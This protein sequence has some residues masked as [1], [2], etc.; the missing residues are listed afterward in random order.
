MSTRRPPLPAVAA[1]LVAVVAATTAGILAYSSDSP[2]RTPARTASPSPAPSTS[3]EAVAWKQ[4]VLTDLNP[5]KGVIVA[6]I[7]TL[8]QWQ[9]GKATTASVVGSVDHALPQFLATAAL[10]GKRAPFPGAPR[11][12]EDYQRAVALYVQSARVAR[13]AT[14]VATGPLQEQLGLVQSRLRHLADRVFD[15]SDVELAAYIPPRPDLEGVE[16]VKPAEVPDWGPLGLA[17][18]PP[19]GPPTATSGKPREYQKDRPQ[20]SFQDWAKDVA[21]A[22]V[23]SAGEVATAITAGSTD[24]LRTLSEQLTRASD[25]LVAGKDPKGERATATRVQLALLIEAEGT[26]A[27]EAATLATGAAPAQLRT[28]AR[29]LVLVADSLWDRRLGVRASGFTDGTL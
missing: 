5:L 28:V 19:L 26:R 4:A 25:G 23:P 12:L 20:E 2:A 29:R 10:L 8:N 13:A 11:A 7:S 24:A 9:A 14:A 18:G 15:Q 3:A 27:A 6:Y 1:V 21:D 22:H 17:A 16:I